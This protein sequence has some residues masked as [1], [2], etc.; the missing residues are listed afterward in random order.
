[1]KYS[2]L[3]GSKKFTPKFLLRSLIPEPQCQKL[4]AYFFHLLFSHTSF[5]FYP[6]DWSNYFPS[7]NSTIHFI[8]FAPYQQTQPKLVCGHSLNLNSSPFLLSFYAYI[9]SRMSTLRKHKVYSNFFSVPLTNPWANM[10]K[11]LTAKKIITMLHNCNQHSYIYK[12]ETSGMFNR[13]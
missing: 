3:L 10:I 2:K 6:H 1:M 13:N 4:K 7:K 11:Y 9:F 12:S 5:F 8:L